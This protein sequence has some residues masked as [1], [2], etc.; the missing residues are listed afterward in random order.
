MG[1]AGLQNQN[2]ICYSN[3][4]FQAIASCNHH[5][6]LFQKIPTDN[7]RCFKLN[8]EFITLI[9]SMT[10]QSESIDPGHFIKSFTDNY[11]EFKDEQCT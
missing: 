6:K 1:N 5:T 2:V 8:Y 11:T 4:I 9:N 3:A 7:Q 10:T